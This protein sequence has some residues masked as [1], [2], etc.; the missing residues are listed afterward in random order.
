MTEKKHGGAR[1]G[2]GNFSPFKEP[3]KVVNFR[4]PL[5]KEAE[6]R[7]HCNKKLEEFKLLNQ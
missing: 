3:T 1:T 2:A 5:S 7:E 6:F 4:C